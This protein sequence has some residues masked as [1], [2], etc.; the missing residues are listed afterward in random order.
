LEV[1]VIIPTLNEERTIGYVL[2]RIPKKVWKWGE[3]LVVD[4]S[5]DRTPIIAEKFGAKVIRA[6]KLGKGYAMKIGAQEAKGKILVFLDG[7]G[8][9]P[10]EYI[11]LAA[12]AAKSYDVVICARNP[13]HQQGSYR[14]KFAS[15]VYMP[16]L[17]GLFREIG[18]EIQGDPL[19][20]FR[21]M[22]KNI[23]DK[24]KLK[25]NDFFIETEMNIKI[26]LL[27]LHV[28]EIPIPTLPRGDSIFRSKFLRSVNQQMRIIRTLLHLKRTKLLSKY[29]RKA[30]FTFLSEDIK[31]EEVDLFDE[32]CVEEI[33]LGGIE[34]I[35]PGREG[36]RS[37]SVTCGYNLL[38]SQI[39]FQTGNH[40]L[41]IL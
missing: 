26:I 41:K 18:F 39:T 11:P 6:P 22:R 25:S 10:P 29:N 5:T 28:L 9:D 24:L 38:V 16:M 27:G 20:G 4:S 36:L 34:I 19:A 40:K 21:A 3:V 2:S 31:P 13:R 8:T 37:Y 30:I 35:I 12:K 23:W 17:R 14:Y 32:E 1:S 15:Y 7:D 33:A